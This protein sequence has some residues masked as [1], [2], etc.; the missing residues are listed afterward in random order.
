MSAVRVWA[1]VAHVLFVVQ[2]IVLVMLPQVLNR[3]A[4]MFEHAL[5]NQTHGYVCVCS[6]GHCDEYVQWQFPIRRFDQV[7]I[8]NGEEPTRANTI[9]VPHRI[10]WR[11]WQFVGQAKIFV[12]PC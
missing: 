8:A 5:T 2:V 1:P 10:D 6:E 12:L 11:W 7:S 9:M 3:V 4:V